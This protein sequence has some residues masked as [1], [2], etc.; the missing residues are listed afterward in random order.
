MNNNIQNHSGSGDNVLGDKV[1]NY[2]VQG[3]DLNKI[4]EQLRECIFLF[5]KQEKNKAINILNTLSSTVSDSNL[6]DKIEIIKIYLNI[7]KLSEKDKYNSLRSILDRSNTGYGEFFEDLIV[8]SLIEYELT[9]NIALATERYHCFSKKYKSNQSIRSTSLWLHYIATVNTIESFISENS[10]LEVNEQIKVSI[11]NGFLRHKEYDKAKKICKSIIKLEMNEGQFNEILFFIEQF[12][13]LFDKVLNKHFWLL[14]ANVKLELDR[15]VDSYIQWLRSD[16]K[17]KENIIQL[18]LILLNHT[19]YVYAELGQACYEEAIKD[20]HIKRD[21]SILK[22]IFSSDSSELAEKDKIMYEAKNDQEKKECEINRILSNPCLKEEDFPFLIRFVN[23]EE[24]IK[25]ISS[26]NFEIET[27]DNFN[28]EVIKGMLNLTS[29]N[30]TDNTTELLIRLLEEN[31]KIINPEVIYNIGN[32]LLSIKS[33]NSLDKYRLFI[34]NYLA[35]LKCWFSPLYELY[36]DI[37]LFLNQEKDLVLFLES[38]NE[39]AFN[40]R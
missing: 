18:S 13:F 12:E 22:A 30:S 17:Y 24:L 31:R 29:N 9:V 21:L 15:H 38:I 6:K 8:S 25:Y 3:V 11:I 33:I 5:N 7:D 34:K 23:K 14:D 37:L 27:N 4:N 26:P 32:I 39:D 36:S 35:N 19:N 2:Q 40:D 16:N 1:I 10:L 20:K 28:R